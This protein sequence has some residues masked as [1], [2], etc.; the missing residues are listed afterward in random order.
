[1]RCVT[2]HYSEIG[3]KGKNQ[4]LFIRRLVG[5]IKKAT[6]DA[7]VRWIEERS[8]RLVLHLSEGADWGV[9]RER[10]QWVFG[11]ANYSL[12]MRVPSDLEA[13]KQGVV[14][15][16]EPLSFASFRVSTRRAYKQFPLNSEGI[17]R[18][19]GGAVLERRQVKV[20]LEHPELT[21]HVEVLPRDIYYSVRREPGPGGLPV[22]VSGRVVALL[23]GGIDSPVAASRLLKRGCLLTFVHFHSMPFLDGSSR[24]KA[25]EL[26]RLLTR[27]QYESRLYLVPFGE[28]QR[29]VVAGAPSPLRVVLY[30]RLMSRIAEGIARTERAKAL[31]TGE[32]LG[33][34]ASQTLDNLAVIEE[35]VSLPVLRPLIGSDKEEIVQQARRLGSY[36][37][38][39]QPDQDCCRFFVPRHPATFSTLEEVRAAEG[40]LPIDG[41]VRMGI[42]SAEIQG[43]T[44]PEPFAANGSGNVTR[45]T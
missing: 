16:L 28:I 10:L 44:F 3:L 40:H 9:I 18:E 14:A 31:V 2:V 36:D 7:G 45:G 21:V 5:N 15:A 39:V 6:G 24:G 26:A 43:F 32:S 38:S 20:D 29:E 27:Y 41:L 12:A 34:V 33:Q 37:I 22:G 23:S 8:G 35:A 11:V 17:N 1:M 13:L 42:D 25:I 30:R 19:V 4:P